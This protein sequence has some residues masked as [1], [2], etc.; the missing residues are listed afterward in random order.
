M[1]AF[2]SFLILMAFLLPIKLPLFQPTSFLT[3]PILSPIP[4][5]MIEHVAVWWLV[6]S[7]G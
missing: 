3:F 6:I 7:W 5:G 2:F 4:P 1:D